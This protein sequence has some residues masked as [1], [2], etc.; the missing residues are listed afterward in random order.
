MTRIEQFRLL[1]RYNGWMNARLYDAA[2]TLPEAEQTRDRGAFFGSILGT[3]EHVVVADTIWLKRFAGHPATAE[4]LAGV[5]E[6]PMPAALDEIRFGVLAPLRE[7]RDLLDRA[8]ETSVAALCEPDLDTP[9]AYRNTKGLPFAKPFGLL[10]V[11]FFN[12]QTHHRGQATTLFSQAGVD[13][14]VTDLL[15]LIPSVD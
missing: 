12:H 8:I 1:A 9:L 13:V 15:A 14:G 11:H 7:R 6:L 10:L 5:A 4:A 3:L 2:A